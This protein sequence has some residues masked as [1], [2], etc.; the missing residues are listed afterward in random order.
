M[1]RQS[2][3]M[4]HTQP[5]TATHIHTLALAHAHV[6]IRKAFQIPTFKQNRT[7]RREREEKERRKNLCLSCVVSMWLWIRPFTVWIEEER[8]LT[9]ALCVCVFEQ[10][11]FV[12]TYVYIAYMGS[13]SFTYASKRNVT[14][15]ILF[16]RWIKSNRFKCWTNTQHTLPFSSGWCACNMHLHST[17]FL[18][19]YSDILSL[20]VSQ[21]SLLRQSTIYFIKLC[22]NFIIGIP[23]DFPIYWYT[24]FDFIPF[25]KICSYKSLSCTR[26]VITN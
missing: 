15:K 22:S 7:K 11:V 9:R 20:I 1:C 5:Y 21:I 25:K 16:T 12:V 4:L 18:Y 26:N 2:Q 24:A 8:F 17:F 13:S 10:S 19:Q 3:S 6:V 14:W 23:C